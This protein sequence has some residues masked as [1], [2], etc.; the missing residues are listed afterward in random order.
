MW[1]AVRFWAERLGVALPPHPR[2]VLLCALPGGLEYSVRAPLFHDGALHRISTVRPRPLERLRKARAAVLSTDPAGLHWLLGHPDPPR[3]QLVLSSAQRLA[4]SLRAEATERL[5][6]PVVNYFATTETGPL[7]WECPT[8]PGR[9]HL[10]HPDAWVEEV[11]GELAVTRLRDSPLPL[12]R[13]KTGDRGGVVDG[14]CPCGARGRS[15]VAF[16]GRE[17]FA[18]RTPDGREVDAWALSWL[19]KDIP[20]T[21]FE[22]AQIGPER[23]TLRLDPNPSLDPS[24]LALR[25]RRALVRMGFPR[26]SLTV[27]RTTVPLAHK[28]V[29]F[30]G[31]GSR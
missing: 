29:P 16:T 22:L 13:Y 20:L 24:L 18:F 5:G 28:P 19:F 10:L 3:P 11:D 31:L 23:F 14:P 30:V 1:A 6:A 8:G 7:A 25:L 21:R 2:L 15:I 4:P 26:P 9:F 12:L 17:P 27:A